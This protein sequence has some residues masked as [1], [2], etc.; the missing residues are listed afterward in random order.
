[1]ISKEKY[2]SPLIRALL[3]SEQLRRINEIDLSAYEEKK[4]DK[5]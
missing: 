2:M 4:E 3:L 5:K 1:M